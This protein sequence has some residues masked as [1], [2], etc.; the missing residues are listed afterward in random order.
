MRS[1][2][3]SVSARP[4][5]RETTD[6]LAL[7]RPFVN[8]VIDGLRQPEDHTVLVEFFGP[9]FLHIYIES[10]LHLCRQR[11]I[12]MGKS[13][14]EFDNAVCHKVEGNVPKLSNLAHIIVNNNKSLNYFKSKI[15]HTIEKSFTRSL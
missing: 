13:A 15:E 8:V 9:D 14:L 4:P 6:F 1:S 2:G 12:S 5:N 7:Y 10:P 3:L 11:Y